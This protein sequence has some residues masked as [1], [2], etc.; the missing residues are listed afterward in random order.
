M[1]IENVKLIE[2]ISEGSKYRE[3]NNI[4]WNAT[5]KMFFETTDLYAERRL[6]GTSETQ[7]SF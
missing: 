7:I 3:A 2:L 5:E 6:K 1:V 4:Y